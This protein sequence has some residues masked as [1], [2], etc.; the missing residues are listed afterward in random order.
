MK[1][2]LF[3]YFLIINSILLSAQIQQGPYLTGETRGDNFGSEASISQDGNRIAVAA[4]SYNSDSDNPGGYVKIY[5][6]TNNGWIQLGETLYGNNETDEFGRAIALSGNGNRI[7]IGAPKSPENGSSSGTAQVYQYDGS[8]WT[9]LGQKILGETASSGLG[10]SVSITPDG[11]RMVIGMLETDFSSVKIFDYNGT[12]WV[13]IGNTLKGDAA[14][15]LGDSVYITENGENL[16]VGGKI[17]GVHVYSYD[18]INQTWNKVGQAVP[19]SS[20]FSEYVLSNDGTRFAVSFPQDNNT[21]GDSAGKVMIYHLN[22][23]VWE[24]LGQEIYGKSKFDNFGRSVVIS[25]SGNRIVATAPGRSGAGAL[26]GR[27]KVRVYDYDENENNWIQRGIEIDNIAGGIYSL[28]LS[29]NGLK[30]VFGSLDNR[31]APF[32]DYVWVYDIETDLNA[33]DINL[34]YGTVS[35][36]FGDNACDDRALIQ[37]N[38]KITADNS[39]ET[40]ETYS[41]VDGSYKL[42]LDEGVY[43]FTI[44]P[45]NST[46]ILPTS[47]DVLLE[48]L[49]ITKEQNLCINSKITLN[50]QFTF[51]GINGIKTGRDKSISLSENGEFL[52]I[53]NPGYDI[54]QNDDFDAG[55]VIVYQ[56]NNDNWVPIGQ[57]LVGT[58]MDEYFGDKVSLSGNGLRLAVGITNYA[59]IVR[60]GGAVKVYEL[61]NNLWTE[62]GQL[63]TGTEDDRLGSSVSLS[64][65]G[66]ILGI[67]VPEFQ[68]NGLNRGRTSLYQYNGSNWI[69]LGQDIEGNGTDGNSGSSISLSSDGMRV[70]IGAPGHPGE[71]FWNEDYGQVRVFEFNSTTNSWIQMGTDIYGNL[72]DDFLGHSVSLSEDGTTMAVGG[73]QF[74]THGKGY[75]RIY[76]YNGTNWEQMGSDIFGKFKQDQSGSSVWLSKDGSYI[77]IGAPWNNGGTANNLGAVSI[78][79]F[80]NSQWVK[81]IEDIVD[82]LDLESGLAVCLSGD[83]SKLAIRGSKEVNVYSLNLD[84]IVLSNTEF[85]K[86]SF[87]IFPIPSRNLVHI[88]N[89]NEFNVSQ[90]LVYGINGKLLIKQ[91]QNFE[92]VNISSLSNGIYFLKLQT[93]SGEFIKK[94]IKE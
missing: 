23:S 46:N 92:Y 50:Q 26:E 2:L 42:F 34:V 70:A 37:K 68:D 91:K 69:Q 12:S 40:V 36:D 43:N 13:Q 94:I 64:S 19:D 44:Q 45:E 47:E 15:R 1:K 77:V 59:E 32:G 11:N 58:K 66:T 39:I 55:Q 84:N 85:E 56:N 30:F 67:G 38:A 22:G 18:M 86:L 33:V 82:E 29:G 16:M 8:N 4:P 83:S 87:S 41:N 48:G 60:E 61:I 73:Y 89:L 54:N 7:V 27:G 72:E 88:K 17:G 3:Y 76:R 79:K 35:A 81:L 20:S 57:P 93:E 9:Q 63:I 31:I 90:I 49:N 24:P 62:M 5:E 78:Y 80:E 52:A 6:Q 75:T 25:K 28:A 71:F 10:R 53:G 74:T 14:N 51:E 65:D 21:G